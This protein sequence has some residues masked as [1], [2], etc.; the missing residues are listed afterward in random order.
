M[1]QYMCVVSENA[2]KNAF[3]D[4]ISEIKKLY[5]DHT[6]SQYEGYEGIEMGRVLNI[7]PRPGKK[8]S[9]CI[10]Y[11]YNKMRV[12]VLSE[13][14][15]SKYFED[16]KVDEVFLPISDNS[17]KIPETALSFCFLIVNIIVSL[18]ALRYVRERGANIIL[19]VM[20]AAIYFATAYKIK[21]DQD[22]PLFRIIAM[23]FGGYFTIPITILL[24]ALPFI[25]F[26]NGSSGGL[27]I[28]LIEILYFN[29]VIP[30]LII[31]GIAFAVLLLKMFETT[32]ILKEDIFITIKMFFD[33]STCHGIIFCGIN[34]ILAIISV[35]TD[36]FT[37]GN[38]SLKLIVYFLL[39][40]IYII[41]A[42]MIKRKNDIS[43]LKILFA[44]S[45]EYFALVIFILLASIF[46][47]G[48]D[49]NGTVEQIGGIPT[50]ALILLV[51]Y[52]KMVIPSIAISGII[53]LIIEKYKS[54]REEINSP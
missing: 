1:Y 37:F 12:T 14:Y 52:Y 43:L 39:I 13:V 31:S 35:F 23:Q 42:M 9:V 19:S 26:T 18:I 20:L 45:G 47:V 51:N 25:A 17:E 30:A 22:I 40:L 32:D 38:T 53:T 16:K 5:P 11:E 7:S 6:V 10:K 24:F 48:F 49:L 4:T 8:A 29:L 27:N 2:D 21:S 41:S 34:I 54:G 15:L 50:Y 44:Q 46:S 3:Y 33:E 28:I 36:G